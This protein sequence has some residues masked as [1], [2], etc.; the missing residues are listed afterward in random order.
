[1]K[2]SDVAGLIVRQIKRAGLP[3]P[4]RELRFHPK[5]RWRFDF[6]YPNLKIAF[7]YEG[8]I[9]SYGAHT[10]GAHFQSD[11]EKY[12]TAALMGWK[13][14]RIHCDMVYKGRREMP[15][16]TNLIKEVLNTFSERSTLTIHRPLPS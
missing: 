1:M 6:A 4:T 11:I 15:N 14:F 12:N 7:E 16:A 5:R 9:F 13:V 3:E 2:N 10:R 8:G